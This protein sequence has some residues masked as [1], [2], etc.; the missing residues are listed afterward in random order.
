[1]KSIAHSFLNFGEMPELLLK[2]DY[3]LVLGVFKVHCLHFRVICLPIMLIFGRSTIQIV[4]PRSQVVF[5]PLQQGSSSGMR[6]G[7]PFFQPPW[8]A[9]G[10][11]TFVAGLRVER[12]RV[13]L[14]LVCSVMLI[15]LK[16]VHKQ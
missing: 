2:G 3:L 8:M 14:R 12:E 10:C 11:F 15:Y 13:V 5:V 16:K 1:M 7:D 4:R 9:P 6:N